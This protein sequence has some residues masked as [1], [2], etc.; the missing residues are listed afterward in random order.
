MNRPILALATHVTRSLVT[1]IVLGTAVVASYVAQGLALTFALAATFQQ[2][3]FRQI[4]LWIAAAAAA[5]AIRAVLL[6]LSELAAQ[7]ISRKTKERVRQRLLDKLVQLGPG[8]LI[9]HQTGDLQATIVAGVEALEAYYSRYLPAIFVAWIGCSGVVLCLL[10]VD[11]KSA[12]CLGASIVILVLANQAWLRWRMPSSSGVFAALGAFNAYFLDSLQGIVTLKLFDAAERRRRSLAERASILRRESMTSLSLTLMRSGI[13]GFLSLGGVAAVLSLNA[14][15]AASGQVTPT[16]LFM[17]LM[18]AREAFRPLD[19]LENA[20]HTAWS[21]SGAVGP[22]LDLLAEQ[23]AIHDGGTHPRPGRTDVAFE[24]V[25]FRYEATSEPALRDLSFH[26]DQ[27]E[28][29]AVVGRS[30][31]GKTTLAALLLR[32]FD[33]EAGTIRIGGLD[34][35][36]MALDDLRSLVSVVSQDTFLFHGTI[37]DNL[38]IAK[39]SATRE[40]IE[41]AVK[42]AHIDHFIQSLPKGYATEIGERGAQLSGGQR[43]RIAIARALLKNAP[44]LILDEATSNVDPASEA[45][46]MDELAALA[47]SRTTLVIAHRLS[48]VVDADRILVLDQGIVVESGSHDELS[49]RTGLYAQLI[50]MQEEAA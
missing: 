49:R 22:I 18:L 33:P 45:A 44:I 32:L 41:A 29:I 39:P 13:T 6:W 35:R 2:R 19:R 24:R 16:V 40:E 14:W 43:Q 37:E 36:Q 5:A 12:V 9:R 34:I 23:P 15:R 38:R 42:A 46:I 21:A 50:Q 11:W 10:I 1:G 30:G 27:G 4:F 28:T 20:F 8:H 25:T 7:E 26:I 3:G 47:R 31:A 48:N 17:T